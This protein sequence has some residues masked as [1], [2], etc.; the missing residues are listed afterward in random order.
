METNNNPLIQELEQF[1]NLM[2][3]KQR[4]YYDILLEKAKPI[5]MHSIYEVFTEEEIKRIKKNINPQK[6]QCF[7]NAFR[8]TLD[9]PG[10][11]Y[12]EGR[13]LAGG[14][15]GAEHAFNKV[16]DKYIDVTFEL[17]L[18]EDVT[19]EQYILIHEFEREEL[20]NL[21]ITHQYYTCFSERK[22]WEQIRSEEE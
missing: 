6:K 16:G 4:R 22:I 9:F 1:R 15:L 21:A 14:V 3:G 18:K 19:K 7:K 8:M 5:E 20:I 12:V 10:V 13:V 2:S 11:E 17:A